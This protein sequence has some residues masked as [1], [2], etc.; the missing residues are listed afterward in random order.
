MLDRYCTVALVSVGTASGASHV[1]QVL[2]G[3][4]HFPKKDVIPF[5]SAVP[6]LH[7]LVVEVIRFRSWAQAVSDMVLWPSATQPVALVTQV[8]LS[9]AVAAVQL[10]EAGY[11]YNWVSSL[12][13]AQILGSP[14]THM[15]TLVQNV[16]SSSLYYAHNGDLPILLSA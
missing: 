9:L 10:W 8:H 5:T 13:D 14:A 6:S 15:K 4:G 7:S 12:P 1:R 2:C 16:L 3:L 11:I